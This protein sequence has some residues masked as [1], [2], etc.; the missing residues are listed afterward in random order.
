MKKASTAT[1]G[2]A[3]MFALSACGGGTGGGSDGGT[4]TSAPASSASAES[5]ESTGSSASTSPSAE[6]GAPAAPTATSAAPSTEPTTAEP[7]ATSSATSTSSTEPTCSGIPA[8][9]AVADNLP[10]V[11]EYDSGLGETWAWDGQTAATDTYDDCAELSA[12]AVTVEGATASSPYQILLFSNGEYIG[13][14]NDEAYGF[15]PQIVRVDDST[16]QV[17][18]VWPG[19]EDAN[20]NP[21]ESAVA[22]YTVDP[23]S[24]SVTMSGELPPSQ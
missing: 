23:E 24:D 9:Q 4:E 16:L 21:T 22:T 14:A 10:Q 7:S 13:T 20:A 1:V 18:Y 3:L 15:S 12:V 11:P 8:D 19:P 17:T 2:L 5:T 6:T